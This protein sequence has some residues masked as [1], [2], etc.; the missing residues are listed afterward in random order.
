MIDWKA[1]RT[2]GKIM[3]SAI[4]NILFL[5]IT[6]FGL[7][8]IVFFVAELL[9]F[10]VWEFENVLLATICSIGLIILDMVW[11]DRAKTKGEQN[12]DV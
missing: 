5:L 1:Y 6:T 7:C 8:S 12:G 2:M 11:E 4:G 10:T 9:G 3:G